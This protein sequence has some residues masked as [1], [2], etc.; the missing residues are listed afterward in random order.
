MKRN[1]SGVLCT[2][3]F[4][5]GLVF[6]ACEFSVS[7]TAAPPVLIK[8]HTAAYTPT[9]TP[10]PSEILQVVC[11]GTAVPEAAEYVYDHAPHP[12]VSAGDYPISLPEEWQPQIIANAELVLCAQEEE[13]LIETCD[14][15]GGATYKRYAY[16][17]TVR[18]LDAQTA[19]EVASFTLEG[20]PPDS[21]PF[22]IVTTGNEST[23]KGAYG[24]H[25]PASQVLPYVEPYVMTSRLLFRASDTFAFATSIAFS[26]DNRYL[27]A[28]LNDVF[29]W[30]LDSGELLH[31]LQ[32]FQANLSSDA[33]DITFS[34]DSKT[35]AIGS[36]T[37]TTVSLWDSTSGQ[38]L[39]TFTGHSDGILE[40]AFSPDGQ[41]L[42]VGDRDGK[43]TLWDVSSGSKIRTLDAWYILDLFFS[44]DGK[45]LAVGDS[46]GI[47]VWDLE[48]G[49]QEATRLELEEFPEYIFLTILPDGKTL[50]SGSCEQYVEYPICAF[51]A[52]RYWDIGTGQIV[53]VAVLPPVPV[54]SVIISQDGDMLAS[55]GCIQGDGGSCEVSQITIWD[56]DTAEVVVTYQAASEFF[57]LAFSPNGRSLAVGLFGGNILIFDVPSRNGQ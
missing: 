31:T 37:E 1:L 10:I 25:V 19:E 20:Q 43:I 24:E 36:F 45:Y 17:L 34:P 2:I 54:D 13:K 55:K 21:C 3:I 26:P 42:A 29:L 49:Q 39:R 44:P 30:D 16:Y 38:L 56:V 41:T 8:T 35:I 9:P 46:S 14:Y 4:I 18:L 28:G 12:V 27:A 11:Q 53:R 7:N 22:V 40:L 23:D 51:G 6:S 57:A 47:G 33:E 52:I 48:A 50:V 15:Q 5:T 32:P